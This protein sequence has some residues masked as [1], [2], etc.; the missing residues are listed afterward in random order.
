MRAATVG[1]D[2]PA[3]SPARRALAMASLVLAGEAVFVPPFHLARYFKSSLLGTLGIDELQ[4]GAAQAWY[5]VVAMACYALG[6]PLA[7]RVPP[8][9][10][11]AGSLLATAVGSVAMALGPSLLALKVLYGFWGASTILLFWAPLIRATRE[12]G[13]EAAQGR[14][15]GVLD[16]G[17]GLVAAVVATGAALGVSWWLGAGGLQTPQGQRDAVVA[18]SLYYAVWCI[19]AAAAVWWFV[20]E[21]PPPVPET[22]IADRYTP[23]TPW[24]DTLWALRQPTVWLQAVVVIAA[25][26]AYKAFSFY[27]LYAEDACGRSPGEAARLTAWLSYLRVGATLGA[28]LLADRV[29][30]VASVVAGGFA[31]MLACFA[32]L[33]A[34]PE[35]GGGY[36]MVVAAMAAA[37]VACFALRGVYFAL[38]EESRAPRRLTG[39]AVGVVSVVGFTPDVFMPWVTGWL[40]ASARES[41]DVIAGYQRFFALLAGASA[42]GLAAAIALWRQRRV[43]SGAGA[44]R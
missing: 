25:Y 1:D 37:S 42:V 30:S 19:A 24:A 3:R 35:N 22:S 17:R 6:G 36:A 43:V 4:L 8:R 5:G 29:G 11:L 12:W 44:N 32:A 41:G 16:A 14:A 15:F 13:G 38:L 28:G 20:A 26:S 7:D 33:A 2:S 31:V 27:G 23:T 21:S 18:L 10:L 34:R 9:K 39:A 40:I